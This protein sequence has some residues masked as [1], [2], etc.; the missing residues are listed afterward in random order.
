MRCLLLATLWVLVEL[1]ALS[2]LVGMRS[3]LEL[4]APCPLPVAL[5]AL[6]MEAVLL[7]LQ[8]TA[9]VALFMAN[10]LLPG[11]SRCSLRIWRQLPGRLVQLQ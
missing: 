6:G 2:L 4:V 5:L 7:L 8:V 3:M 11:L 10:L 1:V 9:T